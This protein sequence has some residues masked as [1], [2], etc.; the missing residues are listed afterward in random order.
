MWNFIGDYV[1]FV[2]KVLVCG[3]NILLDAWQKSI[4]PT[5][6]MLN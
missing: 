2:V 3:Y 5:V 6:Q 1:V 4:S